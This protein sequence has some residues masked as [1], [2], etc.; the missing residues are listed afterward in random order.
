MINCVDFKQKR[1]KQIQT[2]K[3]ETDDGESIDISTKYGMKPADLYRIFHSTFPYINYKV[4]HINLRKETDK[5]I[6][7]YWKL[8]L[9]KSRKISD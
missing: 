5:S 8:T 4:S 2:M 3:I 6:A 9:L 7:N 1:V